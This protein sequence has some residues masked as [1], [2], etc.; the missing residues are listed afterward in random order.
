[1]RNRSEGE[2]LELDKI[3]DRHSEHRCSENPAPFRPGETT[4]L[5]E[6]DREQSSAREDE[7]KQD[8]SGDGHLAQCDFAEVKSCSPKATSRCKSKHGEDMNVPLE[9]C[10][11]L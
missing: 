2:S 7:T 4:T 3:L 1:M 9:H 10:F 11:R 5:K 8:H 6:D